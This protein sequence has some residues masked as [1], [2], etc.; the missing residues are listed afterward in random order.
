MKSRKVITFG[1][2]TE[3]VLSMLK[4]E[5]DTVFGEENEAKAESAVFMSGVINLWYMLDEK[6]KADP[7][8]AKTIFDGE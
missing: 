6:T 3:T 4:D 8:D 5:A 7:N 1:D 2:V